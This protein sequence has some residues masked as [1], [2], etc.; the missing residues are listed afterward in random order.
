MS[1]SAV[2][3]RTIDSGRPDSGIVTLEVLIE[4]EKAQHWECVFSQNIVHDGAIS[5]IVECGMRPIFT[6]RR[7]VDV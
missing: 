4:N 2:W 6:E 7:A 1:R 5:E 3:I